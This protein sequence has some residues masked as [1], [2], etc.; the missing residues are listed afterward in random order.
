M[1]KIKSWNGPSLGLEGLANGWAC[2][3]YEILP[4]WP[5]PKIS[6]SLGSRLTSNYWCKFSRLECDFL[7]LRGCRLSMRCNKR[8]E[9]VA[10]I[11]S[12]NE[13]SSK[14]RSL[15]SVP[16]PEK[17]HNSGTEHKNRICHQRCCCCCC[18]QSSWFGASSSY[19][20]RLAVSLKF[21]DEMDWLRSQ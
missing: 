3:T 5:W 17:L 20:L 4:Y 9:L 19:N 10:C 6:T 21:L 1:G 11:G 14:L 7:G 12:A 2:F 13:E 18:C 15:R 16:A 8:L